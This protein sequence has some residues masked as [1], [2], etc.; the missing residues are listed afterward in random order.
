MQYLKKYSILEFNY[1]I[2]N[3]NTSNKK[4]IKKNFV[5]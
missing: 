1:L 5:F 3:N 2:S 4:K